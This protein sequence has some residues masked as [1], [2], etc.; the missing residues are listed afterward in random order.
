[1]ACHV[2]D[3]DPCKCEKCGGCGNNLAECTCGDDDCG[4]DDKYVTGGGVA[5]VLGS[6]V[7]G[8]MFYPII[9]LC[10]IMIIIA[11]F[12]IMAGSYVKGITLAVMGA[13]SIAGIMFFIVKV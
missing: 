7:A 4:C 1:M 10:I 3:C 2:C 13:G 11:M 9:I 6:V 8:V 12:F 5:Q